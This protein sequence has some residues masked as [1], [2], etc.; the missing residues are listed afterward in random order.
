MNKL[1][2][3]VILVLLCAALFTSAP[4]A[5]AEDIKNNDI[6]D[7]MASV[8]LGTKIEQLMIKFPKLYKNKLFA[9]EVLYEACNQK[10]LEVFSFTEEPWSKGYITNIWVRKEEASV[11]RDSTGGLP[12]YSIA[13]VTPR[14]LRL[15]DKEDNVIKLYGTP[16]SSKTIAGGKKILTYNAVV[17]QKDVIVK[18]LVLHI[19]ISNGAISS[20]HLL[21]DM[22]GAKKPF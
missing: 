20:F 15:G 2:P 3:C 5:R 18:N 16:T 22:P 21:G 13:P 10:Q 14:G 11:C 9:G 6:E 17:D 8:K 12:D 4:P 7:T 1:I 19:E